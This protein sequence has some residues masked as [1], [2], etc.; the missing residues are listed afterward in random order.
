MKN[1]NAVKLTLPGLLLALAFAFAGPFTPALSA[2]ASKSGV[3]RPM[4]QAI[5]LYHEGED[6]EAMDR[7]MDILV[8]G[9]PSEKALANEYITK[10][11]LRMNTGVNTMKDRGSDSSGL[12]E[13]SDSREKQTVKPAAQ[14]DF[15]ADYYEETDSRDSEQAQ[16]ARAAEKITSRIAQMRR[17]LLLELGRGD[18]V[19]IYMGDS[20]PKAVTLDANFFFAGD[21]SFRPGADKTLNALAGLLFTLGKANCLILPEGTAEGDVKIK[22]I[23][24]AIAI[25]SY[26]ESRGVSK[27]RLDVNLTGTDVK[28]PR[29]LTNISGMIIIFDYDKAQRLKDMEDL[30]T[31]GPRVSLGVYPTAIS[32]QNNEGAIVEFSV[33]ESPI[34][35]PSWKF[36]VFQVQKDG[37]RLQLQEITGSGPQYN[38]SFWNGRRK[39]FGAPYPS[40]KYMFTVTATDVEGRETSLS[41]LLIVRPSAEEERAALAKPAAQKAAPKDTITPSGIKAR[42]VSKKSGLKAG[43]TL[44]PKKGRTPLKKPARKKAQASPPLEDGEGEAAPAK[45]AAESGAPGEVSGQ[46]S[47]KIYFKENTSSLTANSEK[48]L[49]Q[50]AETLGYYPMANIALTGYAYSG[51]ANAE[52]MAES[53]A[54]YVATRLSEKYKID[55]ARMEVDSLV[56]E[57]PKSIVEIKLTG[58]E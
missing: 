22:G 34:G 13:V 27:S 20:M 50:V 23:R 57:T 7:F 2:Q 53:R 9:T 45:A 37:T 36:Q 46:V 52:T 10:I 38:Q 29:E 42:A 41:R 18:A 47:Y 12:S 28:F 24:R 58:K 3:S 32:L 17:D 21:T 56:S 54:N 35:Q 25:N 49:A 30:Q 5:R 39:F 33:F 16:K 15:A 14:R 6:T 1:I 51:E 31:K 19:K 40:G 55:R 48:R 26:F 4:E 43:K 44:K 8:K 11:T